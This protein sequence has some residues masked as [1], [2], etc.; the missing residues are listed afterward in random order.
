MDFLHQ[1]HKMAMIKE[2]MFTNVATGEE[3]GLQVKPAMTWRM[4]IAQINNFSHLT[5]NKPSCIIYLLILVLRIFWLNPI[6]RGITMKEII[7][8]TN[9]SG[10]SVSD[11]VFS[12]L[13]NNITSG[14]WIT[15][16]KIPS[17][18]KLCE[19]LQVSRISV[20]SA[21]S[22][23]SSLG[24]LESKQG[25]GTYVCDVSTL[26]PLNDMYSAFILSHSDRLNMLE[27]RKVIEV[28]T[29]G[30]AAARATT[31]MVDAMS[32]TIDTMENAETKVDIVNSD[33]EFHYLLAKATNNDVII[34]SF[35]ILRDSY[36]RMF[37]ENVAVMGA[38]GALSH[39]LILSAIETRN[40]DLARKY[41]EEHLDQTAARLVQA[42][43]DNSRV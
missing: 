34:K 31:K 7:T 27:F 21:I 23:L 10:E 20:R 17:E 1:N 6:L 35:E 14:K 28:A 26:S 16:E 33:L 5:I 24:I 40:S 43:F 25:N 4:A 37:E 11:Y 42:R 38:F 2:F 29:A 32:V 3:R 41:M 12:Y 39:R 22:R 8:P 19:I 9:G 36:I 15:G 13:K 18:S 30:F